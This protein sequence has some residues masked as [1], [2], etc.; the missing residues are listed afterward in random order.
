[1]FDMML[2]YNLL[3][4]HPSICSERESLSHIS[5]LLKCQPHNVLRYTTAVDIIA[6]VFDTA[7]FQDSV[8]LTLDNATYGMFTSP[9]LM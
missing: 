5:A 7:F 6:P 8:L 4:A 3:L 1:M 2:D 9:M